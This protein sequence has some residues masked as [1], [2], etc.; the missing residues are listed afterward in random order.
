MKFS[1]R[2]CYFWKQ[3]NN[4]F[5]KEANIILLDAFYVGLYF[6]PE[7]FV[8]VDYECVLKVF[9]SFMLSREK[10]SQH[11]CYFLFCLHEKLN[12]TRSSFCALESIKPM[13]VKFSNFG[14]FTKVVSM[15]WAALFLKNLFSKI[16]T[17][18]GVT[19]TANKLNSFFATF[20]ILIHLM[21]S[22]L[23]NSR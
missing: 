15:R 16:F 3:K 5:L 14:D 11:T 4:Q 23:I 8:K 19:R 17:F 1:C 20:L 13:W 22:P 12:L 18:A 6:D 9:P 7:L 2:C 21:A 10:P